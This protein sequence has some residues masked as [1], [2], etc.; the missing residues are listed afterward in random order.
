[1]L[2]TVRDHAGSLAACI[3]SVLLLR[4]AEGL[5]LVVLD[6]TPTTVVVLVSS[7]EPRLAGSWA[8]LLPRRVGPLLLALFG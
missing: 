7:T 8:R 4:N 2:G 6:G 1:M 3:V 5:V